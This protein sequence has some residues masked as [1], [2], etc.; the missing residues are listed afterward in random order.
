MLDDEARANGRAARCSTTTSSRSTPTASRI[1]PACCARA[2]LGRDR[3]PFRADARRAGGGRRGSMRAPSAVMAHL[4][5]GPDP[6]QARASRTCRC[7]STCCCCAAISASPAP[8]S[9]RCAATPTCRASA[10]SASPKSPSWCRSTSCKELYGFEP[11][12]WKGLNTVDACEGIIDGQVQRLRRPRRQFRPRRARDRADGAGVA[13]AAADRADRDQAQPQPSGARRDRPICCRASAGSRSTSRRAG[14]R[15][16]RWRTAPR[17]IHG[18]RGR[19]PSRPARI[20][21]S[22][23]RDRRRARQGDAAAESEG[24]LGRLGRRLRQVRDAIE[25]TYP[26]DL[27]GLQRAD[28]AARR[29]PPAAGGARAQVE[30]RDRQGQLHRAGRSSPTADTPSHGRTCSS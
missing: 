28:V 1:S 7:W 17:C 21:C 2:D 24:R 5:H 27:Q 26:D 15:R 11:P 22:E 3:A 13:E 25:A 23:P 29:L 20:C 19:S 9:A 10:P 4:R 16:C 12:R 30:D 14:R 8:A 6:A 18:S